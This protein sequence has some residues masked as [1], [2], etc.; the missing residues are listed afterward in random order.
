MEFLGQNIYENTITPNVA[1]MKKLFDAAV[2]K[3]KSNVKSFLGLIGFYSNYLENYS[4]HCAPLTDLLKKGLPEKVNW[5]P[6][7]NEPFLK[8]KEFLF[9]NSV[10]KLPCLHK[11]FVLRTDSS[12]IAVSA[13]LFQEHEGRLHPVCFASQKLS[14][15]QK[16][17]SISKK[18][19]LAIIFGVKKFYKFLYG[20]TFT[21]ETD[22]KALECIK[23]GKIKSQR[24]KLNHRDG[25]YTSKIL[26]SK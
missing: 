23:E 15:A 26:I 24:L 13:G 5:G 10:L 8:L 20:K 2:P 12:D 6:K 16:K 9:S 14:P 21:I 1:N 7:E 19:A 4:E 3:T 25:L 18:E 11:E 22:H 17:F